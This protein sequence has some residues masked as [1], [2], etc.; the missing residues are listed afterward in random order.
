M[1]IPV[2]MAFFTVGTALVVIGLLV[3]LGA[4][5][6]GMLVLLIGAIHVLVGVVLRNRGRR[7]TGAQ[8]R[9]A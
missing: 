8:T 3:A 9:R 5:A 4:P 2:Y 7:R 6:A 1:T